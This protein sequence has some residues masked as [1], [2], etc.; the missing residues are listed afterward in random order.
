M[1]G[2]PFSIG[3]S[4]YALNIPRQST[5]AMGIYDWWVLIIIDIVIRYCE[6]TTHRAIEASSTTTISTSLLQ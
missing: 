1:S 3:V 4:T 6:G 5:E 2:S